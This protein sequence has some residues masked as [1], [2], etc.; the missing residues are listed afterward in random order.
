[1]FHLSLTWRWLISVTEISLTNL[2][3]TLIQQ[4]VVNSYVCGQLLS[5]YVNYFDIGINFQYN[6]ISTSASAVPVLLPHTLY[7]AHFE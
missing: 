4:V 2:P 1:M 5:L 7:E 3:A 6:S